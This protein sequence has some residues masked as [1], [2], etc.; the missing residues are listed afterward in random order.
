MLMYLMFDVLL[1]YDWAEG[2]IVGF[3]LGFIRGL[4]KGLGC[5]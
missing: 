5:F 4:G 1:F 3:L 2:F